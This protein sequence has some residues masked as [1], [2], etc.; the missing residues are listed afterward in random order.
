MEI[1]FN[2]ADRFRR[3]YSNGKIEIQP[4]T[5]IVGQMR[6]AIQIEPLGK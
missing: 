1:I 6:Q 5:I 2:L 3:F 4:R